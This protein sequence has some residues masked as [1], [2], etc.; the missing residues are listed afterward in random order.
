MKFYLLLSLLVFTN[1][2]K[3]SKNSQSSE[4]ESSS[5]E[6]STDATNLSSISLGSLKKSLKLSSKD[7]SFL[8]NKFNISSLELI[9]PKSEKEIAK[10]KSCLVKSSLKS[11]ETVQIKIRKN[12]KIKSWF[13]QDQEKTFCSANAKSNQSLIPI[14]YHVAKELN[15][16][17]RF[18]KFYPDESQKS[19]FK[20]KNTAVILTYQYLTNSSS[21]Q[22]WYS[23]KKSTMEMKDIEENLKTF[24]TQMHNALSSLLEKKFLYTDFKPD[25]VI[26][27]NNNKKGSSFLGNL[28]SVVSLSKNGKKLDTICVLTPEYFPPVKG[29]SDSN[30][31]KLISSFLKNEGTK[32]VNRM[33][34]WQFCVSIFSLVCPEFEDKR[35]EF[36]DRSVFDKWKNENTSLNKYFKCSK[37]KI[38]SSLT[39]LFDKCLIKKSTKK[40]FKFENI[41]QHEWFNKN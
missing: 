11:Q 37:T 1:C 28:S 25:N 24:F 38:S 29:V 6:S 41:L 13:K 36:A 10:I 18:V 2:K 14:E 32:A 15:N 34:S 39:N 40:N 12:S 17:P 31:K 27:N 5:S 23:D 19:S 3:T 33:L 7:E 20:N 4:A 35:K 26:V 9:S 30:F 8:K 16:K 21:L 22:E